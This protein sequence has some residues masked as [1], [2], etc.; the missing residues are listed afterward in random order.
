VFTVQSENGIERNYIYLNGEKV[1]EHDLDSYNQS[2]NDTDEAAQLFSEMAIV[3]GGMGDGNNNSNGANSSSFGR[4]SYV[5]KM[6]DVKIFDKA[7][8]TEEI[9]ALYKNY[10]HYDDN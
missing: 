6:Y 10:G 5:G 1:S 3:L 8:S 7:F 4:D 9:L 2:F